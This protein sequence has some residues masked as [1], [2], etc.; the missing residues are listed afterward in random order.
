MPVLFCSVELYLPHCHSLKEKRRVI[1]SAQEKLRKRFKCSVSELDHQELW[2]RSRIG[3]AV[4]ASD[5]SFL[6]RLADRIQ[7]ECEQLLGGSLLNFTT[8]MLEH[9]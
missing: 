1:Q 4:I 9:E 3:V 5:R 6:D 8:E 2:Q 7:E